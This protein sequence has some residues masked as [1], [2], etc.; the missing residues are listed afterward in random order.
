MAIERYY[1]GALLLLLVF[2]INRLHQV[3]HKYYTCC[4]D[5]TARY[6]THARSL[7]NTKIDNGDYPKKKHIF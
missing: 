6:G 3:M 5:T 2:V 7:C 4:T 1:S